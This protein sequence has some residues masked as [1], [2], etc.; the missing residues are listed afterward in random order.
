MY[1]SVVCSLNYQELPDHFEENMPVWMDKFHQL[2]QL[3][4]PLVET[5]TDSE[6]GILQLIK[7]QVC[8]NVALYAQ[9]FDEDF[10]VR[11]VI[12]KIVYFSNLSSH[13]STGGPG[14]LCPG[15][16]QG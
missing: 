5:D 14:V 8:D 16:S 13:G 2:L 6:V 10:K 4:N 15:L 7:S 1:T 9:K 12:S 3:E 11:S